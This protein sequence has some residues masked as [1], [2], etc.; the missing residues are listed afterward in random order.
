MPRALRP[1]AGAEPR[2]PIPRA[3]LRPLAAGRLRQLALA[4]IIPPRLVRAG[5]LGLA[6]LLL[7]VLATLLSARWLEARL[8]A[9]APAAA[10]A[11]RV[12]QILVATRDLLPGTRLSA[13]LLAPAD[14]PAA[15]VRAD[16]FRPG[17]P[18]LAA[19]EGA[20]LL[21]PVPAGAPLL[22]GH[23]AVRATDGL[24][25]LLAPGMRAIAIPVSAASAVAGLIA[26]GDRVDLLLTRTLPSGRTV[27]ATVATAVR[28]LGLDQRLEPASAAGAKALVPATVTLEATPR[29]AEEIALLETLGRVTLALRRPDEA[30]PGEVLRKRPPAWDSEA[31]GLPETALAP[32]EAATAAAAATADPQLSALRPVAP[33]S[34]PI[35]SSPPSSAA[36]G[37]RS[38]MR[39]VEVVQGVEVVRGSSVR[40]EAPLPETGS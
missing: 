10:P 36:P 15:A 9:Q 29:Q 22:E 13:G 31:L 3:G 23:V 28:V 1:E 25:A 34:A 38:V 5:L 16:Q 26:P 8:A 24:A 12:R 30:M 19:V 40:S 11:P 2:A 18:R 32:A 20:L 14:W 7:A 21:A 35:A 27:T 33:P 6:A 4:R 17:D 39:G 37:G